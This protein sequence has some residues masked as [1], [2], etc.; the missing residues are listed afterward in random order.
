MILDTLFRGRIIQ[1]VEALDYGDAVSNQVVRL[2]DLFKKQG[3]TSLIYS[4]W[5][6]SSV[7]TLRLNIDDLRVKEDDVIILHYAGFS[8]FAFEIFKKCPAT[9]ITI[10]HNITP[11]HFF[12]RGSALFEFCHEGRRQLKE[13]VDVSHY[14]WG[15]SQYN[16]EEVISLGFPR[17]NCA[18]VPIIVDSAFL[19][20]AEE[21]LS[22][23]RKS[24]SW[25]FVSR[26]AANKGQVDL[27]TLF[28]AVRRSAPTKA[29][30]LY[31]VGN[32]S[33][34]DPYYL[35]VLD[36]IEAAGVNDCV[37][38]TGKVSDEAL[39][40]Y[41]SESELYV[42]LSAH[43]GFGVPLVEASLFG[44]PV[45]ALDSSAV[46]E[47]LGG[48]GVSVSLEALEAEIIECTSESLSELRRLQIANS[49]RFLMLSVQRALLAALSLALPRRMEFNTVSI[50]ICTHN[51]ADLLDRC[52]DYL[53][54]Q[55]NP[56]FEV[57]VVN[58]PSTDHTKHILRKYEG[59]IKLGHTSER[60]L[61]KS[62]NIGIELSS[63]QLI[64]F[65]DDDALP[66]DDWVEKL[67]KE[68]SERPTTL[69][70]IGG[71]AY[72]AG[73]LKFQAEDILINELAEAKFQFEPEL[74]G[75][76]G[77]KRSM[78]GTNTCFRSDVIKKIKGFDE[79]FDYYLDESE[80]SYRLQKLGYLVGYCEDLHLRHEFAKSAN[81]DSKY[82][83][84]WRSIVKNTVYFICAYSGKASDEVATYIQE[85][86]QRERVNPL[87]A[88][89]HGGEIS[90]TELAKYKKE[91]ARGIEEGFDDFKQFPKLRDLS[92][93]APS[94]QV[95]KVNGSSPLI[96]RDTRQLHVCILTKEF[97]PFVP[98]GGIGTLYYHLVSELL[99]MGHYVSVVVP[100]EL[101]HTFRQGRF[102][103]HYVGHE[104]IVTGLPGA[105]GFVRNM[106]WSVS[107]M[108][109]IAGIH[110]KYPIDIVDSALWDTEGLAFSL[111]QSDERPP[112]ILRLVTPFEM[113]AKING[114]AMS[115]TEGKLFNAAEKSLIAN[116]DAIIPISQSISETIC[117][118][119]E[120]SQD[121]RWYQ[122]YCGIA[123]WPTFDY[124]SGYGSL[125]LINGKSLDLGS[126]T[127]I[128]LFL[129][130]LETRKGVDLVLEAS[131]AFLAQDEQ[132]HL[133]LAGKDVESWQMRTAALP[134]ADRIHFLGEVDDMSREKLLAA[135][136]CVVFPS[137]YESF[138]LVPL[139]AFV[140]GTPVIAARAGAIPEVVRDGVSGLL[141]DRD[142]VSKLAERV[143]EILSDRSLR[144]SL[145]VGALHQIR[146]FSSRKSASE[147]VEIYL[148]ALKHRVSMPRF[149][150]ERFRFNE[151]TSDN[152]VYQVY[153][154]AAL[155][156][157]VGAKSG[158]SI[159][160]TGTPG[161][162]T[163]GPY[164]RLK[165]GSY[166][167]K[168]FVQTSSVGE[169]IPHVEVVTT[170]SDT[171]LVRLAL[172]E[173][174]DNATSIEIEF[175]IGKVVQIEVRVWVH[176]DTVMT[177]SKLVISGT[178]DDLFD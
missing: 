175:V 25:I 124:S 174:S 56:N 139:E 11:E 16:I 81:R 68:F 145:S 49:R 8:E 33:P 88:A 108:K 156:S 105:S 53:Q 117:D 140:H 84:N 169:L 173:P 176:S 12:P 104:D 126:D 151:E 109:A 168:L 28:A 110:A 5:V 127:K 83:F 102:A 20:I 170:E 7:E 9:R 106:S 161:F 154:G 76:D 48:L 93:D 99:L 89:A 85:R 78:L 178:I 46:R 160:T 3:L 32:F 24:G 119:H 47:T 136:Y 163:Y 52:L 41:L 74:L 67:L 87:E 177:V 144:E 91:I 148:R 147:T 60:N 86:I 37:T 70:A 152:Q 135:A 138:G 1:L 66:F 27:I 146:A 95:F 128:I 107:A 55:T 141:F 30:H 29:S 165:P 112:L 61:A 79:Q 132:A 62:R 23:S 75:Q 114:W 2:D 73:S 45:F 57:V 80:I 15:D 133:V 153:S 21:K 118:I 113:A 94:F 6:H 42:S 159:T 100:G 13:V 64:A 164:L 143:V 36:A 90:E 50:V 125:G 71:P 14:I 167:A 172:P 101:S 97:P 43:E 116:S 171:P 120:I 34:D 158:N 26:I 44:I 58:G 155:S 123:Y 142:S 31:I 162:L 103:V 121:D 149:Q 115:E 166:S 18:V 129:G 72:Y 77:W 137:R 98:G 157:V 130:R 111:L 19:R 22:G 39:V 51:R 69:A 63:G 10:Y 134:N 92:V 122:S 35:R 59:R 54:Y 150:N 65:I 82:G 40:Q 131:K 17:E 4:K 38:I 96:G